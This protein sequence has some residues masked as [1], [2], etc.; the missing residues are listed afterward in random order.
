[1]SPNRRSHPLERFHGKSLDGI[2]LHLGEVK[3]LR[4]SGWRGFK[5]YLRN[6]TGALSTS[7]VIKGIYSSGGKDGIRPWMDLEY[8]EQVDIVEKSGDKIKYTLGASGQDV[9]LFDYLGKLIPPGGHLMVSYEGEQKI[10][11]DTVASLSLG[12]P[13]AVTPLGHLLFKV[14]FQYIKDWY[15]AEGGFE[16][17]RKLW[18]EKAPDEAWRQNYL[19]RTAHE[20]DAFL[21]KS[22]TSSYGHLVNPAHKR[23]RKLVEIIQKDR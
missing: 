1:M 23:A 3:P 6:P 7:P 4:L 9:K 19:K 8:W 2:K 16:G 21:K 15:L 13:A 20:I 22:F 5:L 18:G 14:G 10:H 17:P 12:I 11:A